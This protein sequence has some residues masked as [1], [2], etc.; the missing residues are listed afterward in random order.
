MPYSTIAD[1]QGTHYD[2]KLV[3]RPIS[4]A[5]ISATTSETAIAFPVTKSED[6]YLVLQVQALTGPIDATNNWTFTAEV[7]TTL[8][9]TY[10]PVGTLTLAK[11]KADD[12]LIPLN[13]Y[14]VGKTVPGA[15]FVR[16]TATKAGT[17][18]ALTYA[19]YISPDAG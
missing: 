13:G 9:G 3:I 6:S 15:A 19:A 5:A 16:V 4:S 1:R 8:G 11:N 18:G 10:T 7:S 2:A 17:A 14:T 12:Y